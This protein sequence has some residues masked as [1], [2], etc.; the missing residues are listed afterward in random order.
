MADQG[1][2]KGKLFQTRM[3]SLGVLVDFW[4]FCSDCY[5]RELAGSMSFVQKLSW[6]NIKLRVKKGENEFEKGSVKI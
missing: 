1:A 4:E 6:W 3:E 2:V 5:F